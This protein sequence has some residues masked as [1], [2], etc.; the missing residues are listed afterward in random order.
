MHMGPRGGGIRASVELR[1]L[2]SRMC[3]LICIFMFSCFKHLFKWNPVFE[4]AAVSSFTALSS[5]SFGTTR[6]C[7]G[8]I[9][10]GE[11][12]FSCR[13]FSPPELAE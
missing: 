4:D 9:D 6:V 10:D 7:L 3:I 8:G 11:S 12:T 2:H 13:A 5:P 1:T